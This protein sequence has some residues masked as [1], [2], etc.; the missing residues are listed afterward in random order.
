M[1]MYTAE[2]F[3]TPHCPKCL[4]TNTQLSKVMKTTVFE[5]DR[6]QHERMDVIKYMDKCGYKS[7]PLVRIY[8][9]GIM[10]DE[11]AGLQPDN[12]KHWQWQV[13]HG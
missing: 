13:K 7:A 9:N 11:W 10:C 8:K 4:V 6:N 12:I 2:L 5:I 1:N 3:R